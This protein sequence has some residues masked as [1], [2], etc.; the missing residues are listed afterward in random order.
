MVKR[1]TFFFFSYFISPSCSAVF[2]SR[3]PYSACSTRYWLWIFMT[4]EF[5]ARKHPRASSYWAASKECWYF[6]AFS[7][8][9]TPSSFT[10]SSLSYGR[11][12]ISSRSVL[13]RPSRVFCTASYSAFLSSAV[14][15]VCRMSK[16]R[17]SAR[18]RSMIMRLS[19]VRMSS[20]A[21][22]LRVFPDWFVSAVL[23]W[24]C[25]PVCCR[26]CSAS[27][28]GTCS[29]S[30]VSG[31]RFFSSA[32]AMIFPAMFCGR[33]MVKVTRVSACMVFSAVMVS[34][35]I[36]GVLRSGFRERP[37]FWLCVCLRRVCGVWFCRI[38][39]FLFWYVGSVFC[40]AG[41]SAVLSG[42]CCY[43]IFSPMRLFMRLKRSL[44]S[45]L[46][47]AASSSRSFM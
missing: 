9:V 19:L 15:T 30:Q 46:L 45:L 18:S 12:M 1:T 2:R 23:F 4:A 32:R 44:S 17:F 21:G 20:R 33:L 36:F 26:S 22:D 28:Y 47:C 7:S 14:W 5:C 37:L 29:C 25:A 27:R 42:C 6:A 3:V 16:R 39:R 8:P 31:T 41:L 10:R 24:F 35:M 40:S 13:I 11:S 38:L 43:F 34:W